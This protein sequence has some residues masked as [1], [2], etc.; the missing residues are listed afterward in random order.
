MKC[1]EVA[2]RIAIK[3]VDAEH[4]RIRR[5]LVCERQQQQ[6]DEDQGR[7]D[8]ERPTRGPD[9]IVG[10]GRIAHRGLRAPEQPIRPH[11]QHDCHHQELGD[12]RE[13]GEVQNEAADIDHA[14]PDAQSLHLGDDDGR[15]ER[16]ADRAH[17]ADH[18]DHECVADHDQVEPQI[19]RLA[20]NLQG[21]AEA[22]Q[23]GAEHEH[24]R[25]QHRLVDAERAHHFAI[26]GGGA[27]QPSE[28][29]LRQHQVEQQ[30][31]DR[32]HG[33]QEQ[34]VA[35]EIAPEDFDRAAQT[36]R[37]RP[38]QVLRSPDVLSHI[39]DDQDERE[40]GEQLEQLRRL[41]DAAQQQDLD[42]AAERRHHHARGDDAAPE[43]EHA[44]HLEGDGRGEIEPQ[45]VERAV[46]DIDDARDAEDQREAGAH[47]EQA[48]RRG[49]AVERLEQE[50]FETH[51]EEAA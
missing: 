16:A 36:R 30:Q 31:Y 7:H 47:E 11:D 37:P 38:E 34:V 3:H 13:L 32:A 22:G 28:A 39:V 33:D 27:D 12:Q 51:G 1:S 43:A 26:L 14:E 50:G 25:E 10:L 48:G 41:I 15:K 44:A 2:N 21:A 8:L 42:Q 35:R 4:Q 20:R 40:G 46:G 24:D 9:R 5:R 45:H 19:G 29:G 17:A 49:E 23:E 18:H 6:S